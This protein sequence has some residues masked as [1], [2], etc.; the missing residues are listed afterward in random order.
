MLLYRREKNSLFLLS[1]PALIIFGLAQKT[2]NTHIKH[3]QVFVSNKSSGHGRLSGVMAPR[4][5]TIGWGRGY[6]LV[7]RRCDHNQP[8]ITQMWLCTFSS[9]CS[10][11]SCPILQLARWRLEELVHLDIFVAVRLFLSRRSVPFVI[12]SLPPSHHDWCE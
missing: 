4:T 5:T 2:H 10:L 1:L 11:V 9:R 7:D 12:Q 6:A 3:P 8:S